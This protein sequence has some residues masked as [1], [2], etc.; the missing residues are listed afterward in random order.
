MKHVE[1]WHV[2]QWEEGLHFQA[3]K[4][5]EAGPDPPFYFLFCFLQNSLV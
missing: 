3:S 2:E 5:G 1:Q 4:R